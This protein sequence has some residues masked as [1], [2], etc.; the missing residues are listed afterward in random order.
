MVD[1]PTV[2]PDISSP[3]PNDEFLIALA[4]KARTVLV[5]GDRDLLGL[6]GQIPVYSPEQFLDLVE[7]HS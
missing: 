3:D 7:E 6:S 2:P 5:S 4:G 1:D